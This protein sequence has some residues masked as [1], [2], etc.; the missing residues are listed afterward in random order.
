MTPKDDQVFSDTNDFG[1]S[2]VLTSSTLDLQAVAHQISGPTV[3][4]KVLFVG[5]TRDSFQGLST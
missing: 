5:T 2:V 3:G 4:A 1:D